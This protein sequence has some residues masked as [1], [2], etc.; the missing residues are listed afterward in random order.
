[1]NFLIVGAGQLGSRHLQ[2]L[3]RIGGSE[4]IFVVDPSNDS[5]NLAKSRAAEIIHTHRVTYLQSMSNLPTDFTLVIVATNSLVREQVVG[6]LLSACKIDYMILEKV[7]FPNV[8]AYKNVLIELKK[9]TTR[10]WVNHPRRMFSHYQTIKSNLIAGKPISFEAVGANWGM[11]CNGLHLL[12]IFAYLDGTD[13]VEIDTNALDGIIHKAKRQGYIEFTG[14]LT[15]RFVSSNSFSISSWDDTPS[16]LTVTVFQ[17][18]NRFIVQEGS[19]SV[20]L[21]L[22]SSTN[23]VPISQQ[24]EALYQSTLTTDLINSLLANGD[25]V[26]PTYE[27]AHPIHLRF[28]QELLKKYNALS[29][30]Q[31][32]VC[33]IT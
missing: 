13:L 10:C 30:Q 8:E 2:G 12:D 32:T 27:E 29:K 33:P 4:T 25:C 26:L 5:L 9:S 11:G 1:M 6:Y 28:V 22:T 7:L 21:S 16:P 15:G 18:Q 3:L 23:Y 14:T 31:H 24:V 20:W 17:S 19:P